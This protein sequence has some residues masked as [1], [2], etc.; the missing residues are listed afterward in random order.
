MKSF[1]VV[2]ENLDLHRGDEE[3]E[4]DNRE[5]AERVVIF[6]VCFSLLKTQKRWCRQRYGIVFASDA[7]DI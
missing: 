7:K 3:E 1:R 5:E 4:E 2:G 6:C